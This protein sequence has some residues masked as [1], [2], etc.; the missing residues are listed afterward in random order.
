M[1]PETSSGGPRSFADHADPPFHIMN[2][3]N[4]TS[5]TAPQ[6]PIC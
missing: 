1:M 2:D 6:A 5:S 3:Y 4:R